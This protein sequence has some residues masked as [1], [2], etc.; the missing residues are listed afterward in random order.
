MIHVFSL[1]KPLRFSLLFL[2]AVLIV[3]ISFFHVLQTGHALSNARS[4]VLLKINEIE[5]LIER[6]EQRLYALRLESDA[7]SI[8]KAHAFAYMISLDPSLV[9]NMKRLEEVRNLLNV[10]ELH[11]GDKNGI[12]VGSTL[13]SHIG[14]DYASDPQSEPFLLGIYYKDFEL[15]QNPQPKGI[16]REMFQYIG[17]ARIDQ[18]GIVQIGYKPERLRKALDAADIH[19]VASGFRI[20]AGGSVLI[21]DLDGVIVSTFDGSHIGDNIETVGLSSRQVRGIEGSFRAVF[22]GVGNLVVYRTSGDYTIIGMLEEKDIFGQRNV[23]ILYLFCSGLVILVVINV[24]I[25]V[26]QRKQREGDAA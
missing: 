22:D 21:C 26:L 23:S 11:V 10:D 20:G 4:L 17:V 6:N 9:S 1:L 25:A 8:A 18:P 16:D 12:L 2:S 3:T 24:Y 19:N 15:A 13:S 5:S 7:Q 14:Y